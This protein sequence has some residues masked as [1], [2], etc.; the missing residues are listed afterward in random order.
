MP[1]IE[2]YTIERTDCLDVTM[3]FASMKFE[4][5]PLEED[6]LISIGSMNY[7]LPKN[8]NKHSFAV[9]FEGTCGGK[10]A[11]LYL[12]VKMGAMVAYGG[13]KEISKDIVAFWLNH[14][15]FQILY[16]LLRAKLGEMIKTVSPTMLDALPYDAKAYFAGQKDAEDD[17]PD[18]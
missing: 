6:L 7:A 8:K 12:W 15:G 17:L 2:E 11:P 13:K 4:Q 10:D 3:K 16:S 18:E 5:A 14:G 1:K 9:Y